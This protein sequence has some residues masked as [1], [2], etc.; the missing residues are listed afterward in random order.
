MNKLLFK[1]KVISLILTLFIGFFSFI[2][3]NSNSQTNESQTSDLETN[4]TSQTNQNTSTLQISNKAEIISSKKEKKDKLVADRNN[5]EAEKTELRSELAKKEASLKELQDILEEDS[6]TNTL[7]SLEKEEKLNEIKKLEEEIQGINRKI[8]SNQAKIEI[9]DGEILNLEKEL[10]KDQNAFQDLVINFLINLFGYFLLILS[11]WIIYKFVIKFLN[12]LENKKLTKIFKRILLVFVIILT[13]LTFL[14]AFI[15]N[16]SLLL[17]GFGLASAALVVALQ[18]FVSS[19]FAWMLIISSK[20]YTVEDIIKLQQSG[21]SVVFGKVKEIGLFRTFVDEME[22]GETDNKERK[23]GR[24][25]SF[26]NNLFLRVS[27]TNYTKEN[28]I[29][30]HNLNL[31]TTFE[32]SFEET[33]KALH[34]IIDKVYKT[35][36]ADKKR[37]LDNTKKVDKYKPTVHISIHNSG[38]KFSIWF[39]CEVGTY[40]DVLEIFSKEILKE[41]S[42]N[43]HLDL[44]YPT[45]RVISSQFL[46][47]HEYNQKFAFN[48]RFEN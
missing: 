12:K 3:I 5:F 9:L 41:F 16:L 39:A 2:Q 45:K 20:Q 4:D 19:F 34:K 1:L 44:A 23:T 29:L 10:E 21:D 46:P 31:V 13:I 33:E 8:R 7:K 38:P 47:S 37:F 11:Y 22:G 28:K 27:I 48:N 32:S 26:P 17:G 25:I 18:D 35:I 6:K 15:R 30:W 14:F 40:R 43:P 36:L 42:Q 24:I